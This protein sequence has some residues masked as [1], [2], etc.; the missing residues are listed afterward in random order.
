MY[1]ELYFINFQSAINAATKSMSIDLKNKNIMVVAMNPGWVK[2]DQGGE[3]AKIEVEHSVKSLLNVLDK[4]DS[5]QSGRL[6]Q[7]DGE[8]LE[9]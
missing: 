2:T 7:Y 4:V 8:I 6:I 3:G 5:S 9:W 1:K